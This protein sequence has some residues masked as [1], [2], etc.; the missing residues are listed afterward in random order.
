[1][2]RLNLPRKVRVAFWLTFCLA[3]LSIVP[4]LAFYWAPAALRYTVT[5]RYS[6][7]TSGD[8]SSVYLGILLPKEGPYQ[9]V[10]T[11]R[12][13]WDGQIIRATDRYVDSL[14]LVG[15][16]EGG[17]SQEAVV[18][19]VVTLYQLDGS[20]GGAVEGFQTAPQTNIE[21][22]HPVIAEAAARI[23]QG[24]SA[25]D[26]YSLYN[27]TRSHL[28]RPEEDRQFIDASALTAYQTGSGSCGEAA[29]LMVAL[30]RSSGIPAQTVVGILFPDLPPFTT[31]IGRALSSPGESHAWVEF[32]AEDRWQMADPSYEEAY[33]GSRL[34]GRSDGRHLSYGE[35]T[36]L[37][38]TYGQIRDWAV[39][40]GKLVGMRFTSI[41]LVAAAD[42]DNVLITPRVTLRKG[43]DG[44][45]F[46]LI[47]SWVVLILLLCR[48]NL[49]KVREFGYPAVRSNQLTIPP[50]RSFALQTNF[51]LSPVSRA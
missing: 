3:C 5:E 10:E 15:V 30:C 32:Y 6:L 33:L 26:A 21:S 4:L 43:W 31:A 8:E 7:S 36:Q 50:S 12:V 46:N 27:F 16:V 49:R 17:G 24:N 14:R 25:E 37:G 34:F 42:S 22:D 48:I 47:L 51:G 19:Y 18:E 38:D 13:S 29:N 20:W 39:S 28:T 1:M 9:K 35:A 40:K 23:A 45:W 11:A 44:R 2:P 41:K